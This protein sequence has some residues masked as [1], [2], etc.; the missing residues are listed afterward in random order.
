MSMLTKT[1]NPFLLP[2]LMMEQRIQQHGKGIA[3][4]E[5]TTLATVVSTRNGMHGIGIMNRD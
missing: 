4:I 5:T 3:T 1:R 2:V